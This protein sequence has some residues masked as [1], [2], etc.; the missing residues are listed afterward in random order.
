MSNKIDDSGKC[1]SDEDRPVNTHEATMA[2]DLFMKLFCIDRRSKEELKFM[3]KECPF[4]DAETHFC[5]CKV[6]KRKFDPYYCDFGAMGD[7]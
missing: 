6:F 1:L 7:L 4:E 5:T 2:L 3:C